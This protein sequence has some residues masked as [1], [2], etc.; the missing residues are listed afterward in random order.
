MSSQNPF[1]YIGLKWCNPETLKILEDDF[2]SFL[3]F[4]TKMYHQR[5]CSDQWLFKI[6]VKQTRKV[7]KLP[8]G[9]SSINSLGKF[10][11]VFLFL[12]VC[13]R[14]LNIFFKTMVKP[15]LLYISMGPS[16]NCTVFPKVRMQDYSV[17]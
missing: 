16:K 3:T 14:H 13:S 8:L 2:R 9:L 6:T 17:F 4:R 5:G 1:V 7:S 10:S 11:V 12:P 15:Y